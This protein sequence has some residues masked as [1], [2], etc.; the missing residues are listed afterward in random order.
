MKNDDLIKLV[1]LI[2]PPLTVIITPSVEDEIKNVRQ[3]KAQNQ[4]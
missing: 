3:D 4:F 1:S 2:S